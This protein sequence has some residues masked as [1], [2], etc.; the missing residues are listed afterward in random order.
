MDENE[1]QSEDRAWDT[2][3]M[4]A[5]ALTMIALAP[6][7]AIVPGLAIVLAVLGL[8]LLG[9]GLRDLLDPRSRRSRA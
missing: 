9:D 4:L 2:A 5:E 8:N 1:R 6:H 3:R 7:V